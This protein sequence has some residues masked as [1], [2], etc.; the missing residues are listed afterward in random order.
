MELQSRLFELQTEIWKKLEGAVTHRHSPWHLVQVATV[1]EAQPE[2]RNMVLRGVNRTERTL[3]VHTDSRSLKC[4]DILKNPSASLLFY[5]PLERLQLRLSGVFK[6]DLDSTETE[7]AWSK[8]SAS[9]RRCYQGPLRPGTATSEL[10]SNIPTEAIDQKY[11]RE[12]FARLVF[13]ASKM[14]WLFLDSKGHQRAQWE[15]KNKEEMASWVA[16]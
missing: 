14:D 9:A 4:D 2:I 5:D 10:F 12:R 3:W 8:L 11:G 16:P 1:R 6:A 7:K 15:F 13:T